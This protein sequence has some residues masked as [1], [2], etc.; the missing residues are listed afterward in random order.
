MVAKADKTNHGWE[1][2]NTCMHPACILLHACFLEV[3]IFNKWLAKLLGLIA[4]IR[5]LS[6]WFIHKL[7]GLSWYQSF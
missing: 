5:A 7:L 2:E 6:C 1:V 4:D 3:K